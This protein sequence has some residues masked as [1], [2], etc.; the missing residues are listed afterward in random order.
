ML[1][2]RPAIS[3]TPLGRVGGLIFGIFFG[4]DHQVL[5]SA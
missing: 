4:V 1:G 2:Q 3:S 5:N